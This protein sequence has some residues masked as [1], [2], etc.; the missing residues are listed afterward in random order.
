M[1]ILFYPNAIFFSKDMMFSCNGQES[2]ECDLSVTTAIKCKLRFNYV[3]HGVWTCWAIRRL[4]RLL[5]PSDSEN[6]RDIL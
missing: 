3:S 6:W 1:H 5:P 2:N 4:S